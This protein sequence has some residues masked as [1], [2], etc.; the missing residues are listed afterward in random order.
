MAVPRAP[1][2]LGIVAIVGGIAWFGLRDRGGGTRVDS[3]GSAG[4]TPGSGKAAISAPEGPRLGSGS[5]AFTEGTRPSLPDGGTV[6]IPIDAPSHRDVFAT[7]TRDPSWARTT[8]SEI[9]KRFRAL[10]TGTTLDA[11]DCRATQC[12]LTIAG[13]T[14]DV[15]AAF[16]KLE[17]PQGLGDFAES[18][19]LSTPEPRDNGTMRVRVYAMFT[20]APE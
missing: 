9:K 10:S 19:L 16:A 17:S 15:S 8:E 5:E 20:R 14:D 18:L 7:Q 1:L 3:Q 11:I 6:E 4:L 2:I 12:E 13:A